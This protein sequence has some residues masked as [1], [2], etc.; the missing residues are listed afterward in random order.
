MRRLQGEVRGGEGVAIEL[1][2]GCDVGEQMSEGE[3]VW[4]LQRKL[5]VVV[6]VVR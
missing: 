6:V 2:G 3:R 5:M 4:L 1:S